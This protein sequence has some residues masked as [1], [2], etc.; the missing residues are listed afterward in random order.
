MRIPAESEKRFPGPGYS[1]TGEQALQDLW[2]HYEKV[3]GYYFFST[4][5][6]RL[7]LSRSYLRELSCEHAPLP[8]S[9]A[10]R[11]IEHWKKICAETVSHIGI[12][13][14][15]VRNSKQELLLVRPCQERKWRLPASYIHQGETPIYAAQMGIREQVSFIPPLETILGIYFDQRATNFVFAGQI[16]NDEPPSPNPKLIEEAQY[17]SLQDESSGLCLLD[18]NGKLDEP[19]WTFDLIHAWLNKWGCPIGVIRYIGPY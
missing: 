9:I 8:T 11:I 4:L 14:V 7:D 10:D 18:K 19:K 13:T 16:L 6:S 5:A 15:L 12:T 2:Q 1:I 3:G 17:F